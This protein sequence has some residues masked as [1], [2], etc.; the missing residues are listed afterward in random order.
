MFC[1]AQI[2][3]A[4]QAIRSAE[5]GGWTAVLVCV[6][7]CFTIAGVA[8]LIKK[9]FEEKDRLSERLKNVED[10]QREKMVG[11]HVATTQACDRATLAC[12]QNSKAL[13]KNSVAIDSLT[14]ALIVRPCLLPPKP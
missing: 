1:F 4:D 9:M 7:F 2:P 8:W 14:Q 12:E 6:M 3:G 11:L 13:E 10:F 5:S